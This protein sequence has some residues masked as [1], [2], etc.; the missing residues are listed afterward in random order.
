MT[1]ENNL[2]KRNND[3]WDWDTFLTGL[4]ISKN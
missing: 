1:I 2:I 4:G 3:Y